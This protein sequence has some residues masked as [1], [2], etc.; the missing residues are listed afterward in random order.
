VHVLVLVPVG[1]VLP[2]ASATTVVDRDLSPVAGDL[3]VTE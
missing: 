3:T 1:Q 2:A